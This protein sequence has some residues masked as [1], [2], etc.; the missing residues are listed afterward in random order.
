MD[1]EGTHLLEDPELTP[2]FPALKGTPPPDLL[3]LEADQKLTNWNRVENLLRIAVPVIIQRI[4]F[5]IWETVTMI[6]VGQ[7]TDSTILSAVGTF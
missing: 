2:Q 5:I 4:F 7:F 3:D 1:H 6:F